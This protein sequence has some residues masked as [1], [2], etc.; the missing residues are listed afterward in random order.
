MSIVLQVGDKNKKV[1]K[2]QTRLSQLGFVCKIDNDY[3]AETKSK[4]W[5]FQINATYALD[6]DLLSVNGIVDQDTWDLLF[7]YEKV[8]PSTLLTPD[9][10]NGIY[11]SPITNSNAST[12][13][14]SPLGKSIIK[15]AQGEV[16]VKEVGNNSG[17]R[18]NEY[19]D[20][21]GLKNSKAPWC[22]A[23]VMWCYMKAAQELGI[24]V[25]WERPRSLVLQ[26]SG[27]VQGYRNWARSK[28]YLITSHRLAIPS[29]FFV[30]TFSGASGHTGVIIKNNT[31]KKTFTTI[32]GNTNS[33][34]AREG[35]GVYIKERTYNSIS[36][37]IQMP[38]IYIE[39]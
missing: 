31:S 23:F 17:K 35:D 5:E 24:K 3:G 9:K 25:V 36:S 37:I 6:G 33:G 8:S 19:L 20:T 38:Q 21:V 13:K 10:P 30:M 12:T 27:H 34:G 18:V 15:F 1:G 22:M 39:N 4:V 26:K 7:A 28:G 29:S 14:L 32:E 11:S 2:L 16:G